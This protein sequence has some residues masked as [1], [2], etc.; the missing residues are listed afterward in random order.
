VGDFSLSSEGVRAEQLLA[1]HRS[2]NKAKPR[3]RERVRVCERARA[4]V[5]QLEG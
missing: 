2:Y 4:R 1:G 5:R 3:A